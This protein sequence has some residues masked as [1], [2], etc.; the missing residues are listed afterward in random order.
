MS[1]PR[2]LIEDWLPAAA[3]GVECMRERGSASA[4]APTTFLHVWWAR[5]P[6][7]ASRAA[8]LASLL[9]ADFPRDVFER[10][11]GFGRPGE[12]LVQIRKALDS[13]APGQRLS[14][15][16]G[17]DRA[18]KA[19]LRE[20]DLAQAHEAARALWGDEI[21]VLDPM[22]GGGSIPLEAARLG[23]RT[24]A[25]EYNPVACSVLE[26]TVDY[27]FRFGPNLAEKARKWADVWRERCEKRL[28]PF[29]HEPPLR[30]VRDYIFARTVPCPDTGHP[31]PLVPDWH[32]LKP[33]SG[34]RV[35]AVPVVDRDAG[36]WAVDIRQ[37]GGDRGQLREQD[38]PKPTYG[39][40]KGVSLFT[41]EL[42]PADWIKSQAQA[43]HM[44]SALYAVV[45]KTPRGLDFQPPQ[46][47]DL[48]ALEAAEAE[49][50]RLRPGWER[51][52]V[53]PTEGIPAGVQ[54]GGR[55]DM[56]GAR[57][58]ADL[59][60]AR[61][62]LCMG[63]LIE[64][65]RRLRG[66]T[67]TAEGPLVAEAV[68]HLLALCIDKF[69]NWNALLTSWN[70]NF[71]GLRSVFDRH[72]FSFRSAWAEMAPCNSGAGLAWATSNVLESWED[73]AEL[74]RHPA[75]TAATITK[76]SAT[77][78][79]DLEDGTVSAVVVDP[80]YDDNVQY[81]ELANF[82]YVWLKRTQ[83][84]RRPEWFSTYLCETG[85][86]AVVNHVRFAEQAARP[87]DAKVLAREHY[88]VLMRDSFHEAHRVL[89]DDGVLTVMF[90]HKKQ[91]AWEALFGALI[92]AGFTITATWPVR[93]ESEHSLHIAQKN[94][95]E[96]TV[97]LVARKRPAGAGR[98]YFN[99][100]MR[101]KIREAARETAERLHGEGLNAVD[102]LVGS[103]GPAM[104]VYSRHDEV[105]TDTG[106]AVSVGRAIDEAA[107]AV[108][109]W[110]LEQLSR[111]G[112]QGVEPEGRFALL[113][114]DV[115]GAAE[116]RFNEAKLLGHAVGRDV[117]DLVVAGLVTKTSDKVRM[118]S[119]QERRRDK[120]LAP[121]EV[122]PTLFG[123]EVVKKR[124]TKQDVL[125]VHPNDPAFRTA[126]DGCHA[127]ALRYLEAAGGAAGVGAAQSLRRAQAWT[128]E[129]PVALL[130]R[131]LVVAAPPAL[132]QEPKS[133]SEASA[134][135][136]EFRAWHAMLAPLF[137][138]EP[139]DWTVRGPDQLSL[140]GLFA[141]AGGED[142][143]DEDDEVDEGDEEGDEE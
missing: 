25:N 100:A 8:V 112:L 137:G 79:L 12:E 26:A 98:G 142:L 71:E 60:S 77:N 48:A 76:G 43:G 133:R 20:E 47:E 94:A 97:M 135:F 2:L 41:G 131:A 58:W 28:E 121:D 84:H 21:T 9:P 82:F 45:I 99:E 70:I 124:R 46:P 17:V 63:V 119:V 132:R 15:S 30:F 55:F 5:R 13:K 51:D 23:F 90:T 68:A 3:I 141:A 40:G 29:Y 64:E 50:E 109:E 16:F 81:A 62:F 56:C 95:A 44:G 4:L 67:A 18:F 32:L 35:V 138:L 113:F 118:L 31:T 75:A 66:E 101:Q 127:L 116:V 106:V 114:W 122:V 65:T 139:P 1:H 22:A 107:E 143:D 61:Q 96:S 111:R 91:E 80:P 88:R 87:G 126:L 123:D 136:P 34:R 125:R 72:G 104:E 38:L 105:R 110:R 59:F 57:K 117:D 11:L 115:L 54:P 78:L 39:R 36:T 49:L 89:R 85:Q 74:P 19:G 83:G 7:C 69:V 128:A 37:V 129:S 73:L 92:E 6:L 108:S 103:F 10:L 53:V 33:K 27:P 134:R 93:T 140:E 86:E 52:G 102:Q 120:A 24:L 130:M 14:F 42:I